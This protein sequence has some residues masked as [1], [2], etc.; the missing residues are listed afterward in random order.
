MREKKTINEKEVVRRSWW[1]RSDVFFSSLKRRS[2]QRSFKASSIEE[3]KTSSM[4]RSFS[5]HSRKEKGKRKL[6]FFRNLLKFSLVFLF[7][8]LWGRE[9]PFLTCERYRFLKKTCLSASCAH[10]VRSR[11]GTSMHFLISFIL[12]LFS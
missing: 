10:T 3:R 9:K 4:L 1:E 11:K 12:F 5:R 6:N 7:L 2:S 8:F